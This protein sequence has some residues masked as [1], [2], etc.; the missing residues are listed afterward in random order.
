MATTT[1][2]QHEHLDVLIIGA[3]ISGVSAA[4]HLHTAL[5]DH[6]YA[7]LEKRDAMGGTWDLFRYP[8]VRSDSDMYTLGF[9]F[10]PWENEKAIAPGWTIRDYVRAAAA[11]HGVDQHVRYG[12]RVLGAEWDSATARWTVTAEVADSETVKLTANFLHFTS[13]YYSYENP[14]APEFPGQDRFRGQIIHPQLWPED[15]DYTNKRVVVIGSGAT[16]VTLVPS[17]AQD[18][19]H[20]T[21]LQRSPSYIMPLPSEDDM[22]NRLRKVLPAET[23]YKITRATHLA[24]TYGF[25][26]YFRRAPQRGRKFINKLQTRMLPEG[27]PV[28]VHFNPSYQPWDQ[29]LCFVP[30]GDLFR[31]LRK[32]QAEIVTDTIDT[33]TETG[34]KLSSGAELAADIIITATGLNLELLGG[35]TLSVDGVELDSADR[36]FYKS[37]MLSDL[38]NLAVTF[39]Y[40]NASWTLK[41]DLISTYVA[42]LLTYMHQRGYD[43]VLPVAPPADEQRR[44]FIP[45]E[46]GYITR[47]L[48]K[49][50]KQGSRDPWLVRQSWLADRKIL[51]HG[52]IADEGLRFFTR[53]PGTLKADELTAA[54]DPAAAGSDA[55]AAVA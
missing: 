33:F 15:L 16:A 6:R 49:L 3:G 44:P 14:Y 51:V 54:P 32:G 40:T 2:P 26:E 37:A 9:Q 39:G 42:R 13:G 53:N 48:D 19:A 47:V 10:K 8:G 45:L 29:R 28:D 23:A 41:A 50:P 55:P 38:P 12:H 35:A 24:L 31:A 7:I 30:D 22:A 25:Y 43:E 27:Y 5:P 1:D 46:S 18:T 36:V 52:P 20:I 34:I 4:V 17:M 11:E 21:M